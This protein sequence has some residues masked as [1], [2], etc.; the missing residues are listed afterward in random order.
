MIGELTNHLWQSTVFAIAVALVALAFR[1][2]R[3]EVRYWLWLS[4]SLKFI[5]PFSLLISLGIRLW[6][7]L[8]EGKIPP[9]IAA[10][11]VSTAMIQ[12]TQPFP[13]T[14]G[15]ASPVHHAIGWMSI[16]IFTLWAFGF[17]CVALM[18]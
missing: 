7:A 17:F 10:P 9:H 2:N 15:Y 5:V 14:Y 16:A 3:A 4:A 13:E 12:M 6:D 8:P 1:K 18:R 11:S